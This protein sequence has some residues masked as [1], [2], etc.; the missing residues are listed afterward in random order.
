[1]CSCSY[2]PWYFTNPT[3][4][5]HTCC[6]SWVDPWT[7]TE[8]PPRSS[9]LV[10]LSS[11]MLLLFAWTYCLLRF[12]MARFA[13][14]LFTSWDKWR[15]SQVQWC[16]L[17][18]Q[19]VW[20][21]KSIKTSWRTWTRPCNGYMYLCPSLLLLVIFPASHYRTPLFLMQCRVRARQCY[22]HCLSLLCM[23]GYGTQGMRLR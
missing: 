12:S 17:N 3:V 6:I 14:N 2:K 9:P 18:C 19:Q 16:R 20:C 4:H 22:R 5:V 10:T 13:P 21:H 23:F 8:V 7:G 11:S 15:K 1:M